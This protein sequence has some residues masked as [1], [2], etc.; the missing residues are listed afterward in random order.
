VNPGKETPGVYRAE[1]IQYNLPGIRV[2]NVL[3]HCG[4]GLF[5][6]EDT[7]SHYSGFHACL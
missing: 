3:F 4:T 7:V 6:N 1:N 2:S 5:P